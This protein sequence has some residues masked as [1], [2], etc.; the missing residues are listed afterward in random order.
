MET[1]K[2]G[3]A[4][5][6]GRGLPGCGHSLLGWMGRGCALQCRFGS[7][8]GIAL[9]AVLSGLVACPTISCWMPRAGGCEAEDKLAPRFVG[10]CAGNFH[11]YG[12]HRQGFV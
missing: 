3:P 2:F 10:P 1:S 7:V 8:P 4:M 5:R 11:L 12:Y 9:R 6:E